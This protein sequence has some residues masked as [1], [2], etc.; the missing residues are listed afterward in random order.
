MTPSVYRVRASSWGSLFDCAFRWEGE[1]LLSIRKPSGMR[2]HLG[3]SVHAATAAFDAARLPGAEPIEVDAAAGVFVDALRK[4]EREVD[5]SGD[6]LSLSQAERIG[7]ALVGIY[8]TELAPRF[9][10]VAVEAELEPLDIDCGGGIVVR[11]TG[12]MDR[13]RVART[14][15]GT[16]IPDIKT[17]SRVIVDGVAQVRGRAPQL[18]TYQ[19]MYEATT[20]ELTSGAQVI[21]LQT[22]SRPAG[23]ASRV[24]D[25]R[26]VMVGTGEAPGLIQH[27]AAM[28]RTGLFPPNT[29]SVLCSERYCARW[30]SCPYHE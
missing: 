28:F 2:A 30:N 19:L 27:A 20:G 3:T 12:T 25:A 15:G 18:G 21:A 7:L 13:A 14:D 23:A 4:P 26:R 29:Q 1:H 16:V 6:E 11:L 10:F 24:I 9:E 5:F 17:G 8:C 22:S